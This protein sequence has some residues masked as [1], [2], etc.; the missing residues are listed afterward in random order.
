MVI[1]QLS[2]S[3]IS[4]NL[5]VRIRCDSWSRTH[6]TNHSSVKLTHVS[7]SAIDWKRYNEKCKP[8]CAERLNTHFELLNVGLTKKTVYR[9]V[10]KNENR[11]KAM[12]ACADLCALAIDGRKD[13]AWRPP[14]TR[15][16]GS[17][18]YFKKKNKIAEIAWIYYLLNS[19]LPVMQ[20]VME[21]STRQMQT[22]SCGGRLGY[23]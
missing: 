18:P 3:P 7:G 4:S 16:L 2:L 10:V 11:L 15:Y 8:R 19:I 20:T 22:S 1:L 5:L 14:T 6:R 12:L 23:N 17:L 9:G 21:L 13:I